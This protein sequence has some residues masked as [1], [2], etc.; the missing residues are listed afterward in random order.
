MY[1]KLLICGKEQVTNLLYG[2]SRREGKRK[3]VTNLLYGKSR[4]ERSRKQ[5]TNLL[6]GKAGGRAAEKK[7]NKGV[8]ALVKTR[9]GSSV[10]A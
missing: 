1:R 8:S 6:Y 9:A 2:E 10:Y 3:Q 7:S 5:V 4:W